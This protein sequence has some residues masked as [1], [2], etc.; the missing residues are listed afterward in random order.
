MRR[1]DSTTGF[2]RAAAHKHRTRYG[3]IRPK[4]GQGTTIPL[5]T[6]K[7]SGVNKQVVKVCTC[8]DFSRSSLYMIVMMWGGNTIFVFFGK[9]SMSHNEPFAVR[10]LKIINDSSRNLILGQH[11]STRQA[12]YAKQQN[13]TMIIIVLVT[14]LERSF[15]TESSER[16]VHQRPWCVP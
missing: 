5:Y 11:A 8:Q 2:H 4:K 13:A 1:P 16:L 10:C 12:R 14:C 15:K 7:G 9:R 3:N 6:R